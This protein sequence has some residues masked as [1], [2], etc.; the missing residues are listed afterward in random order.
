MTGL[1]HGQLSGNPE[2]FGRAGRAKEA[3]KNHLGGF[4][5]FC[6]LYETGKKFPSQQRTAVF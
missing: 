4:A 2:R 6:Y 3:H 5:M 1:I